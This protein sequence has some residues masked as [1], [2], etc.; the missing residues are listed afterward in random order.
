MSNY[1]SGY[2]DQASG[3]NL[4]VLGQGQYSNL[5][6]LLGGDMQQ[7][8]VTSAARFRLDSGGN[9]NLD[10]KGND[11]ASIVHRFTSNGSTF[12]NMLTMTNDNAKSN[13]TRYAGEFNGRAAASQFVV[14]AIDARAPTN[15]GLYISQNTGGVGTFAYNKGIDGAGGFNFSTYNSNG[16]LAA[17]NMNLLTSGE[18]QAPYYKKTLDPNDFEDYA[19]AAFDL[20]GNLVRDYNANERIRI[21]ESRLTAVE[22]DVIGN[23][24]VPQKVNEII[25]RLN[26]LNFFSNNITALP[27]SGASS[28]P[29]GYVVAAP[30]NLQVAL[31]SVG[32]KNLRVTWVAPVASSTAPGPA[33][34]YLV[35]WSG[36]MTASWN[37]APTLGFPRVENVSGSVGIKVPYS[38]SLSPVLTMSGTTSTVITVASQNEN[39]RGSVTYNNGVV[40]FV[41]GNA[42]SPQ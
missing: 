30:T 22:T 15:K 24:P 29:L 25:S 14:N 36:P 13:A 35:T 38:D 19:V 6:L 10:I 40:N 23:G 28:T 31:G 12:S 4:Q 3:Y 7:S 34:Y 26:G 1:V 37:G 42:I 21:L 5:N 27:I 32:S 41:A 20:S 2:V 8:N 18:V 16:T 11:G 9:S 33:N 39:V 17:N